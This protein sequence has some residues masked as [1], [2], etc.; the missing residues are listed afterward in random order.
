[1]FYFILFYFIFNTSDTVLSDTYRLAVRL[2][3]LLMM[4]A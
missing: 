2:L 3:L 1:M 4:Q